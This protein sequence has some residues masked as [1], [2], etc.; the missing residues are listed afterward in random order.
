MIAVL[1]PRRDD[2]DHALMPVG[3]VERTACT[4]RHR[5]RDAA[6]SRSAS[7]SS[8]IVDSM[9]RRSRL[10][11]SSSRA[12][13][14]GLALVVGEQAADAERHVGEPPRGVEARPGDEAEVDSRRARGV[15][16]GDGEQ[17]GDA[18]LRAPGA[19]ARE[20]CATRM[21]LTW[22][23]RTT[24]A[25][26]PS[27]TRSS[28]A[29]RFGSARAANAPRC[30]QPRAQRAQHVEHDADAGDVL[31]RKRAA[32]LIRIDDDRGRRK[33]RRRADDDR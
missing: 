15:A 21:R 5:R 2:A 9:S 4:R 19:D 25:T 22:S 23:R 33:R 8:C 7:A 3:A 32:R 14:C 10:S 29:A 11:R 12:I 18:G 13:G 17:R 24:S 20:P 30:A 28:S 16:A 26:V 1:Q 6:A 31:A 27:A